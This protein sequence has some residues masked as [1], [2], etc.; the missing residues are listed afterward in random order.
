MKETAKEVRLSLRDQVFADLLEHVD[1][2]VPQIF[3]RNGQGS[4]RGGRI[5]PA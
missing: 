2:P 5:R 4:G 1:V 3:D